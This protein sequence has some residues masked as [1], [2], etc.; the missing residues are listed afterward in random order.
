M[1]KEED[2]LEMAVRHVAEG[3]RIVE[4][5]RDRI[6]KLRLDGHDVARHQ[7]LLR[8]FEDTLRAFEHFERLVRSEVAEKAQN[9]NRDAT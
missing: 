7:Q 3:R 1:S 9:S 8:Q 6:E 4:L 5:Q 2:E